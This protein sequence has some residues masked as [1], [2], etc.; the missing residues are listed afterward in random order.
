MTHRA[1]EIITT[2]CAMALA[3]V[4]ITAALPK[5]MHPAGFSLSI[6]RYQILPHGAVNLLA[7]YLPW[8]E[9]FSAGFI[10]WP[11]YRQA[12]A[13][14][15]FAM[16]LM[17]TVAIVVSMLRGIDVACGCFTVDPDAHRLGWQNV[18]RNVALLA[19]ATWVFFSSRNTERARPSGTAYHPI[20]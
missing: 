7:I 5:I 8:I 1:G 2:L 17:F 6:Y 3:L 10:L 19:M 9:L 13:M 15:V 11:R 18:F 20:P 14:L 16:L 4:F 12:A